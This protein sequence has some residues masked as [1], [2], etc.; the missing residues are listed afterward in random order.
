MHR[1]ER[2]RDGGLQ[3]RRQC[4]ARPGADEVLD[5]SRP[6]VGVADAAR[7][8]DRQSGP[9]S[10][11]LAVEPARMDEGQ[12]LAVRRDHPAPVSRDVRAVSRE[13]RQRVCAGGRFDRR[14]DI[15]ERGRHRSGRTHAGVHVAAGDRGGIRRRASR[16]R[17]REG[18]DQDEDL[19]HRPQLQSVGTRAGVARGRRR[20]QVHR[21]CCVARLPRET[22]GDV[23]RSRPVSRQRRVLDGGRAGLSGS[24]LP[25]RLDAMDGAVHRNLAQL[26]ARHHR[27]EPRAGR[28][29]EAEHRAL[30]QRRDSDDRQS[31][32]RD[33]A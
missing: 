26:G 33:H 7:G 13:I 8:A 30:F 11:V 22:D 28:S 17:V 23:A 10:P 20:A 29:G 24:Q 12:Q 3:L 21:R 5:R 19:D 25:D 15:T 2:L 9:L 18:R 27:L 4:D 16:P 31:H 32:E 14:G 1:L 6:E